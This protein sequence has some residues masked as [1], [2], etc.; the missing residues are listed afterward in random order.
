MIVLLSGLLTLALV[1]AAFMVHLYLR[2]TRD[3]GADERALIRRLAESAYLPDDV[4]PRHVKVVEGTAPGYA[5]DP[6]TLTSGY[7]EYADPTDATL[8]DPLSPSVAF[9][10]VSGDMPWQPDF[11][12]I[13]AA[14]NKG[15]E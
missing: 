14:R 6:D 7:V 2:D 1:F 5:T 8:P 13:H 10:Q 12:E 15:G 3:L 9:G 11:D 4:P